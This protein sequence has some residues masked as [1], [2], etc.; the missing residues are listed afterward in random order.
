MLM[1]DRLRALRVDKKYSQGDLE[2]RTGLKRCYISRVENGHTV[3][4]VDTLEKFA[5]A[6]EIPVYQL[7][8]DGDEPPTV[9]ETVKDRHAAPLWG[10]NGRD[11]RILSR[12]REL[13]GHITVSDRELL[14]HMAQKMFNRRD[15][16]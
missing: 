1:G 6:L 10:S 14:L 16:A 4:S 15:G 12:F 9:P 8:Y 13:L 11:A 7:F 2:T 3:P 5:R